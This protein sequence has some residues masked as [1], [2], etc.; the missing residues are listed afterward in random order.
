VSRR[1]IQLSTIANDTKKLQEIP[2]IGKGNGGEY[3]GDESA[4]RLPLREE[5]LLKYRPTMAG[6]AAAAGDGSGRPVALLGTRCRWGRWRIWRGHRRR[7]GWRI[8][9]GRREADRELRKG[10]AD[11]RSGAGGS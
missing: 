8:A 9:A 3:S 2:G 5:L 7:T 6:A 1:A 11:Y 4:E 10:I